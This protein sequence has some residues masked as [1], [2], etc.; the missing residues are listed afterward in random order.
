MSSMWF[1]L[2]DGERGVFEL[3][4]G[5]ELVAIECGGR[6]RWVWRGEWGDGEWS[7]LVGVT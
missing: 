7:A 5:L 4:C 2:D 1:D 3:P 6:V